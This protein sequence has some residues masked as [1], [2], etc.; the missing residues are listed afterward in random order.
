M[1]PE[2]QAG[3]RRTARADQRQRAHHGGSERRQHRRTHGPSAPPRARP[4]RP[5]RSCSARSK[6]DEEVGDTRGPRR[7]APAADARRAATR[8]SGPSSVPKGV[9]VDLRTVNGGVKMIGLH[10]D[11]ARPIHQRRDYRRPGWW[12]RT[13]TRPSPTVASKSS[14]PT[15]PSSGSIELDSVNGG[16]SLTLPVGQQGGHLG[17]LRQR[18]HQRHR[19]G[20]R[21]SGRAV[22][23]PARW[24]AEWRRDARA[25]GNRERRRPV[26]QRE[27][28]DLMAYCWRG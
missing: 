1:D 28:D 23:T 7:G 12:P 4:T 3:A 11:V 20:R 14:W 22:E 9:A 8:S 26:E 27:I 2:L 25:D 21:D 6:C 19:A 17:A 24:Q 5:P 13:S 15:R 10:G 16:V 18:R